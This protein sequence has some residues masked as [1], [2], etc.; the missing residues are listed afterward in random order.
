MKKIAFIS[1]YDKTDMLIYISKILTIMSKKVLIIDTTLTQKTKYIVPTMTPTLKYITTFD[2]IDIAIGFEKTQEVLRYLGIPDFNMYDYVI[3]DIDNPKYYEN[4]ELTP[5]DEHCLLT[6]FD[7]YSFQKGIDVLRAIKEPTNVLKAI[8]TRNIN[9]EEN[10][11]LDFAT[12][13]TK[14]KWKENIVYL[15]FNTEDIYE[16]FQN[17]RFTKVKFSGLS[18]DY[19]EG[20]SF[21]ME[22]IMDFTRGE[23]R[24]AIKQID[25][26]N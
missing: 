12:F 21:L 26:E 18:M 11:Y 22:N 8:V 24:K 6:T 14:V 19:I 5:K 10:E 20:L 16:I 13:N 15:P 4:F 17:Q 7:V 1:G 23:I 9:S 25:R 3:F 2:G